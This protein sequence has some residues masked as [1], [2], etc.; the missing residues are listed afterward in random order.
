M[1]CLVLVLG[2]GSAV[3]QVAPTPASAVAAG[4]TAA[5]AGDWAGAIGAY[6]HAVEANAADIA[7]WY[8]LGVALS[9]HGEPA[10]AADAFRRVRDL[11]PVF[12]QI[13]AR[14]AAA[15]GR[16]RYDAEQALDRVGYFDEADIRAEARRDALGSGNRVLG[17]RASLGIAPG[18]DPSGDMQAAT[19]DGEAQAAALAGDQTVSATPID[20]DVYL[21][22]AEAHRLAGEA[23][24]ARYYVELFLELGGDPAETSAL[25]A[26]IDRAETPQ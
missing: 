9:I 12:P 11:D 23:T 25:R 5:A 8:K 10:A 4:D 18:S 3:A 16:A 7:A 17:V 13:D 19:V 21:A 20:L 22:A 15:E 14:I 2:T 24:A 26:A 1:L 6:Q